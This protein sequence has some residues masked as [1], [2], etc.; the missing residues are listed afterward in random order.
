M[1]RTSGI[2][3]GRI[4]GKWRQEFI[5]YVFTIY[6]PSLGEFRR[7]APYQKLQHI[8]KTGRICTKDNLARLMKKMKQLYGRV[9]DFTP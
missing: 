3:F 8:P 5:K 2:F 9:F 4:R 7:A 6:R 1:V